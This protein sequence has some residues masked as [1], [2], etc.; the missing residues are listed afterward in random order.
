MTAE[1]IRKV[2]GADTQDDDN[3]NGE[4]KLNGQ[5]SDITGD[6]NF[7]TGINPNTPQE[8]SNI[9]SDDGKRISFEITDELIKEVLG[10]EVDAAAVDINYKEKNTPTLPKQAIILSLNIFRLCGSKKFCL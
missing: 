9:N 4:T 1:L 6:E 10:L 7:P 2:T 8:N 3:L 5:Q